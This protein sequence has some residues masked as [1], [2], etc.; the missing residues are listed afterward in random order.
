MATGTFRGGSRSKE[1]VQML[2]SPEYKDLN[3]Q[4]HADRPDYGT[5]SGEW[6]DDIFSMAKAAIPSIAVK[7][8]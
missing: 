1:E 3:T 4:L 6:A 5:S 8:A 7:A 2:I